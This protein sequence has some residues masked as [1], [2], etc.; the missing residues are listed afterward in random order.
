M[1]GDGLEERRLDAAAQRHEV[2]RL[3]DEAPEAAL[4]KMAHVLDVLTRYVAEG[5]PPASRL[6]QR[7][8][9]LQHE[10]PSGALARDVPGENAHAARA[11]L[12]GTER[13]LELLDEVL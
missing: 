1:R 9:N 10:R 4:A 2:A 5:A 6:V 7:S 8:R 11:D 3:G 12:D 13:L